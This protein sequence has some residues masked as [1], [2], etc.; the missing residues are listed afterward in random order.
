VRDLIGIG[1]ERELDDFGGVVAG[2]VDAA[3]DGGDVQRL[4][5][6]AANQGQQQACHQQTDNFSTYHYLIIIP[7]IHNNKAK[8]M[9]DYFGLKYCLYLFESLFC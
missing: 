5:L 3:L 7:I 2:Q 1:V 8:P 9:E 6:T 4:E